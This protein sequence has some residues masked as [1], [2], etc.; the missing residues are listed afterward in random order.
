MN[1]RSISRI[2]KEKTL[3][4]LNKVVYIFE[5]IISIFFAYS[6]FQVVLFRK[7]EN[8]WALKYLIVFGISFIILSFIIINL[9][10]N[11]EKLEKIFIGVLIPIGMLYVFFM[12]PSYAP[13]EQA[14]IWKSYQVSTGTFITPINEQNEAVT[15]VPQF[16]VKNVIPNKNKYT[17]FEN[18][19]KNDIDYN[20]I[21]K[22]QNPAQGY[23]FTLY[24]VSA[25][26]FVIGKMFSING[27]WVIYLA[28]ILNYIVFLIAGYYSIKILPFGKMICGIVLFMPMVLQQAISISADSILNSVSLFFIS[29]TLY[30]MKKPEKFKLY[31]QILYFIIA[32][33]IGISKIVYTPLIG[34]SLLLYFN[35]KNN[36]KNKNIFILIT[37]IAT[38]I[39][40]FGWYLFMA[41]YPETR[42]SKDFFEANNVNMKEQIKVVVKNPIQLMKVFKNE[43]FDGMHLE[44]TIGNSLGWLNIQNSNIVLYMFIVLLAFSPFLDKNKEE[45]FSKLQKLFVCLVYFS[46]FGLVVLGM[47]LTYTTVGKDEVMGV[48][49]RYFIPI[50]MLPLLSLCCKNKYIEFK[51][52]KIVLPIILTIL[53]GITLI[54]IFGFFV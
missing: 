19:K 37:L 31:E 54:N 8:V 40:S 38:V 23:P 47:Y 32:I 46:V 50:V 4:L 14:H 30:L 33:L 10:R 22:V 42:T 18:A 27:I 12:A 6:V 43:I 13:D 36:V 29:Y 52:I 39:T 15:E 51:N 44:G 25:I 34:L 16:F 41:R 28:R 17:Q 1:E 35:N 20:D 26:G 9:F 21:T 24:L 53:N 45:C 7:I 49:G 5:F 48:Q 2:D 11:K 3:K